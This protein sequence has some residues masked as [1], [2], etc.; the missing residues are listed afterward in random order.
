MTPGELMALILLI[1]GGALIVISQFISKGAIDLSYSRGG[2]KLRTRALIFWQACFFTAASVPAYFLDG[3]DS[4][5][6]LIS[7]FG[8]IFLGNA[9][10]VWR[11]S[12]TAPE[13]AS[14][15]SNSR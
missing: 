6:M 12:K 5:P 4:W 15:H 7:M 9:V 1:C 8:C 2:T 14:T 11:A 13:K 3:P 10:S